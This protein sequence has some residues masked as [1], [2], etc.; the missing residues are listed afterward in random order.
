MKNLKKNKRTKWLIGG[1]SA[2]IIS[3][4]AYTY[5]DY[6]ISYEKGVIPMFGDNFTY[7]EMTFDASL[8]YEFHGANGTHLSIPKSA[9]MDKDGRTVNGKVKVKFREFHDAK[10]ILLSGIPMQMNDNRNE[11]M[12][13]AGMMELRA[14]KG[15]NELIMKNGKSIKV[16]LAALNKVDEN[17]NLYFLDNDEQWIETG[18]FQTDSNQ[19]KLESIAA[20]PTLP[21]FPE[22]PNPDSS[23]FVFTLAMDLKN[24]PYLRSFKDVDWV[25][26]KKNGESNPYNE[27][28]TGWDRVKVKKIDKKENIFK[29]SFFREVKKPGLEKVKNEKF[30]LNAIPALKGKELAEALKNY[31]NDLKEYETLLALKELEEER[32]AIES[33]L[34]NTFEIGA[35]G[36]WNCDKLQ[37]TE[38]LANG[39]YAFDFEDQFLPLVNKVKLYMVLNDQNGVLTYYNFN[40]SDMPF[41]INEDVEIFAVLPDLKVA[42]VS[43]Q[44]YTNKVNNKTV[45]KLFTNRVK[46]K[47][48]IMPKEKAFAYIENLR[49]NNSTTSTTELANNN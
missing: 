35:L 25:M 10:S 26:V 14:Y 32:L 7:N 49:T 45:S 46:F 36:F 6:M 48:Q 15:E 12:Q 38:I 3:F 34:V 11:Y 5:Y 2:L 16:N 4:S 37:N 47:S 40:W 1:L 43:A 18:K 23:D 17:F 28:R 29:I 33:D 44:E 27:L 30:C 22:N 21:V 19:F 9:F 42:Y 41:F 24:A 20:I 39:T 13:S 8:G 31:K